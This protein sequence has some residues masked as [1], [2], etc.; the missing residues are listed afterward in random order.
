MAQ[1]RVADRRALC[2]RRGSLVIESCPDEALLSELVSGT[3][4]PVTA[5]EL[6]AHL[7]DCDTCRET[8]AVLVRDQRPSAAPAHPAPASAP[9]MP[10]RIGRFTVLG[11]L[12]KGGMGE[13]YRARDRQL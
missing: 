12:G 2:A 7:D 1:D 11:L 13:V 9:P 5:V 3:V 10:H 6:R 8:V 4:A